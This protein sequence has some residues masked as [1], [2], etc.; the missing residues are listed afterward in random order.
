V[1]RVRRGGVACVGWLGRV[2][3][4]WR[5]DLRLSL[6]AGLRPGRGG[7][8]AGASDEDAA[9]DLARALTS[10][11]STA[12]R[13]PSAWVVATLEQ[14]FAERPHYRSL[15][16]SLTGPVD[17]A[18]Q[19]I[20]AFLTGSATPVAPRTAG[21]SRRPAGRGA[22]YYGIGPI[23]SLWASLGPDSR[24]LLAAAVLLVTVLKVQ[25]TCC[26]LR[27]PTSRPSLVTG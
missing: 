26:H 23:R 1:H 20:N 7:P 2:G 21:G 24:R 3:E 25:G 5:E 19:E 11:F 6:N 22:G 13:A 15:M 12:D 14:W 17:E 27:S 10:T 8:A 18:M 16:D 4:G 9:L